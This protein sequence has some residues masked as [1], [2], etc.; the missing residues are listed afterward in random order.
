MLANAI[1]IETLAVFAMTIPATQA[2]WCSYYYDKACTNPANGNTNFDCA[3]PGAIGS[4]GAYVQCHTTKTNQQDCE[5]SRCNDSSCDKILT[6]TRVSPN[7]GTG[8][9]VYT[10]GAGPWYRERFA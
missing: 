8:Q 7:G 5:I 10:G 4:G 1:L 6:N 2:T 9:C 3:N